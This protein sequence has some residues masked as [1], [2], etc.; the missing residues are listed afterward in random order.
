MQT[1]A[2]FKISAVNLRIS[3]NTGVAAADVGAIINSS[4]AAART[5]ACSHID[6]AFDWSTIGVYGAVKEFTTCSISLSATN[7]QSAATKALT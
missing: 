7:T 6:E 3:D 2:D 1:P 5:D 4:Q